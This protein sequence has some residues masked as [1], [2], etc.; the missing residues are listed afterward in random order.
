MLTYFVFIFMTLNLN[1]VIVFDMKIAEKY[2]KLNLNS[3]YK[4]YH[5]L[6]TYLLITIL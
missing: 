5:E 2:Q 6:F 4:D 1:L 3:L